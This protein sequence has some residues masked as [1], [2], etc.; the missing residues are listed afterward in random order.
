[1]EAVEKIGTFANEPYVQQ[2]MREAAQ[3]AVA[4]QHALALPSNAPPPAPATTQTVFP[5]A[6]S[7]AGIQAAA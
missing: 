7:L 5:S 3:Q 2:M 6:Q 1:M 4:N